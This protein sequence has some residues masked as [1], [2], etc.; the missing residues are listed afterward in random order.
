MEEAEAAKG[1]WRNFF[2][3]IAWL[4]PPYHKPTNFQDSHGKPTQILIVLP[5]HDDDDRRTVRKESSRPVLVIMTPVN[6]L[7]L[8]TGNWSGE[9]IGSIHIYG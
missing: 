9:N 6:E 7:I 3:L 8:P 5:N 2:Q 1:K 4:T